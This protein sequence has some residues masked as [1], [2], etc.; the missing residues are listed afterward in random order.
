MDRDV[1]VVFVND[2]WLHDNAWATVV[3]R[4]RQPVTDLQL[5]ATSFG[6]SCFPSPIKPSSLLSSRFLIPIE[7]NNRSGDWGNLHYSFGWCLNYYICDTRTRLELQWADVIIA[8]NASSVCYISRQDLNKNW[9]CI[10]PYHTCVAEVMWYGGVHMPLRCC[11][12]GKG[13]NLF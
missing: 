3:A 8:P 4:A 2:S 11:G 6:H 5:M 13:G 9:S 12:D 10:M 7:I 1:V